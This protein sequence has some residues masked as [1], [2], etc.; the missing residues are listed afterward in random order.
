MLIARDTEKKKK[1][2][3]EKVS[4]YK[5]LTVQERDSKTVTIQPEE[6]CG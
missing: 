3:K 4:T 5:L 2:E 1:K 6:G